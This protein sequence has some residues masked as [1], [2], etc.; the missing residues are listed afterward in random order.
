M[1]FSEV[2]TV[3][4]EGLVLHQEVLIMRNLGE[5]LGVT[6][7]STCVESWRTYALMS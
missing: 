3:G 1:N 5:L 6:N 2:E 4:R 7:G